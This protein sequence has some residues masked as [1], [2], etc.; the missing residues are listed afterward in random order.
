VGSEEIW[1]E[2]WRYL[3]ATYDLE[4]TEY[5]FVL[6][7]GAGWIKSGA[8]YIPTARYVMD[9]FHLRQ[10]IQRAAG[11]DENKRAA[12]TKA[13]WDAGWTDMNRLLISFLEEAEQESRRESIEKVI[14]YLNNNWQG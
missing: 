2:I 13:V 10:A 6:G 3:D 1:G 7:D 8:E 11:A 5:I 12:L 14:K 9:R 4:E